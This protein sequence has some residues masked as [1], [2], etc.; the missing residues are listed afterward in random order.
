[1]IKKILI[2]ITCLFLVG[3]EEKVEPVI[4][5]YEVLGTAKEISEKYNL[6]FEKI[7]LDFAIVN[8][9]ASTLEFYMSD[10]VTNENR[11][12][13]YI[14]LINYLKTITDDLKIYDESEKEYDNEKIDELS[15]GIFLI[16]KINEEKYKISIYQFQSKESEGKNYS[17]Y[18]ITFSKI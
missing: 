5:N 11:K 3:C 12:D 15:K 13:G 17:T 18:E 4:L 16:G 8:G 9:Y 6:D 1:M 7:D 10:E 2:I 14:T